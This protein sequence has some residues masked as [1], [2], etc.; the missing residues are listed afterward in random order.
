MG[1]A[2]DLAATDVVPLV[3]WWL[4]QH[5]AMTGVLGAAGHIG[6]RNEA[7]WPCLMLTDTTAG[8]D[9]DLLR[10]V[11]PEIQLEAYGDLDGTPG[12]A[13]LRAVLYTALGALRELADQPW[14]YAGGPGGLPGGHL[15]RFVPGGRLVAAR[16][17]PAPVYRRCS[18]STAIPPPEIRTVRGG[19]MP[20]P[21]PIASTSLTA[22]AGSPGSVV[23]DP[24]G[25]AM[26]AT[27]G[28]TFANSGVTVV[29]VQNTDSSSADLTIV[30]TADG[31]RARPG[32][33]HA[34]H[35][36]ATSA[37]SG[38]PGWTRPSTGGPSR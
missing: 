14:P 16:Q 15:G 34:S 10:L 7:P 21:T 28:N 29:R 11:S 3:T 37:H 22:M 18:A 6:M 31:R 8:S 25:S 19:I 13:A 32:V 4:G 17:R 9:G 26:D 38:S 5:P 20:A 2:A 23:T 27:N 1:A 12:K 35:P 24:A 30:P 36:G 33:R